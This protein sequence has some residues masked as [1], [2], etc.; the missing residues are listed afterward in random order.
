MKS[1]SRPA[2]TTGSE[3]MT[4]SDCTIIVQQNSGRRSIVM[5]GARSFRIVT[6]KLIAPSSEP[7][8]SSANEAI[9]R[10]TPGPGE[11]FGPASGEY[12]VQ[13]AAAG[14]DVVK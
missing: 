9:H 14:P 3:K 8:P 10:L 13:P 1:M 4:S 5:P 2:V 7:V 12:D 6:M 11:N